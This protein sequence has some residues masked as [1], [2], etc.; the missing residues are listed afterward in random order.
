MPLTVAGIGPKE[1]APPVDKITAV[2][3]AKVASAPPAEDE[4]VPMTTVL[5][6]VLAGRAELA[7]LPT[8]GGGT[9]DAPP[10]KFKVAVTPN[11]EN[12]APPEDPAT[13]VE[14]AGRPSAAELTPV[15]T[16][17]GD[18]TEPPPVKLNVAVTP[19]SE[20][21]APPEDTPTAG[22]LAGRL[23]AAEL[24]G[25]SYPCWAGRTNT[26]VGRRAG[27]CAPSEGALELGTATEPVPK[28][29][30]LV[31]E[32]GMTPPPPVL[33]PVERATAMLKPRL[34]DD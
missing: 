5:F 11:S 29:L 1:P 20:N 15:P 2:V 10:V 22:E 16:G 3:P 17:G 9:T 18:M 28:T 32:G 26:E 19:N 6:N 25:E 24:V 4:P 8:G 23:A 21:C 34:P 33:P 12:W 27:L 7:P 31:G 14:L 30:P 13:P